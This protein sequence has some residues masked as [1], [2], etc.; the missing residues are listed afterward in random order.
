[1]YTPVVKQARWIYPAL[2]LVAL[3]GAIVYF[4]SKSSPLD[5]PQ[6]SQTTQPSPVTQPATSPV[7]RPAVSFDAQHLI[8]LAIEAQGTGDSDA[9]RTM[10]LEAL[11]LAPDAR[12]VRYQLAVLE[13]TTGDFELAEK[14]ATE[15]INASQQVPEAMN[16]RGVI[17]ARRNDFAGAARMFEQ[18]TAA[19]PNDPQSWYNWSE[20]L[21]D[22]G[23][24][25]DAVDK[26]TQATRRKPSEVLFS[27]KRRMALI[28]AGR[29]DELRPDLARELATTPTPGDW[30]LTAAALELSKGNHT[31]TADLLARARSAMK[32]ELFF[33]LLQDGLFRRQRTHPLLAPFYDVEVTTRPAG[34][35]R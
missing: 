21:R 1:V 30:L 4:L 33:A 28:E 32:P 22:L 16:L 6:I 26:L 3:S 34:S 13:F 20:A 35:P 24:A 9:A 12:G 23:R 10:Y 29:G 17:L 15:S 8:A 18:A 31:A 27:F 14:Y 11:R 2:V 7:T 5:P 19:N 25:P